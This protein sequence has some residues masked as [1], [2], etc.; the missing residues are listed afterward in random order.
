MND[1]RTGRIL[2]ARPGGN[3][4]CPRRGT[5]GGAIA[6]ACSACRWCAERFA[7]DCRQSAIAGSGTRTKIVH[8][9]QQAELDIGEVRDYQMI[10]GVA[11]SEA[12]RPFRRPEGGGEAPCAFML[13]GKGACIW[14]T[15]RERA[16]STSK[17]KNL[18]VRN[19]WTG[20]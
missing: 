14:R 1:A 11:T 16:R 5:A 2:Q 4:K 15:V 6:R 9:G 7:P 19:P 18:S 12:K 10:K 13:F 17:V 20:V 3:R 8:S